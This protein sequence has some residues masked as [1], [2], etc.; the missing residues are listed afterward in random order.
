LGGGRILKRIRAVSPQTSGSTT[1]NFSSWSD[2]GAATHNVTTPSA[3]TTYT[4]SFSPVAVNGNGLSGAYFRTRDLT[5]TA[6]TRIDP[7]VSF[8]WGKGAP[9]TGYPTDNFSAR[10]TGQVQP[11]F[12]G[13]TTF[14]LLA[15]DGVRL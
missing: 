11:Q 3:A 4:A 13:P 7:T 2:S 15:D 10:W 12:T 8:D 5:G 6:T 1:W 14:Y 9:V